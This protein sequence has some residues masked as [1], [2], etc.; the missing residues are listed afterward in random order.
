M[1]TVPERKTV[2]IPTFLLHPDA[3]KL[4]EDA[5]DVDVIYAL[6]E[7][8]RGLGL[9]APGRVEV[10]RE[11]VRAALDRHLPE[12]HALHAMAVGGHML[13][14][15]EMFDRAPHLEVAFIER[16]RHRQDRRRRRDPSAVC[17]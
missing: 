13:L 14:T 7:G 3:Y 9:S 10:R 15:A 16:G 1:T 12:I 2:L 11:A 6:D 5:D 8:E 4:L 17:W